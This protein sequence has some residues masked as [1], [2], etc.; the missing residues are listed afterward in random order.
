MFDRCYGCMRPIAVPGAVCPHCGYDP[1]ITEYD[2]SHL[3]AGTVLSGRYVLGKALGLGSFGITYI[4]WD[5]QGQCRVTVKEFLPTAFACHRKGVNAVQFYSAEGRE[6]FE[7]GLDKFREESATLRRLGDLDSIDRILDWVEENGTGYVVMEYL[8]GQT[9]KARLA[10]CRAMSFPEAMAILTPVLRTLDAVHKNG[11]LHRDISPDNIFLCRDGRVKLLDFG[12]AQ[13]DLLRDTEGLSIVLKHG[14]APPE[15]YVPH[16]LAGP[17]TDVFGAAATLYKM[18]TGI[19]PPDVPQRQRE[20]TLLKP[21]DIDCDIPPMAEK[22]MLRALSLRPENRYATASVFLDA[23]LADGVI[24]EPDEEEDETAEKPRRTDGRLQA[25]LIG[26]GAA[27]VIL[28]LVVLL[29][30]MI[31]RA[32]QPSVTQV[33]DSSAAEESSLPDLLPDA[34]PVQYFES[35]QPEAVLPLTDADGAPVSLPYAVFA[36]NGR[37]GLVSTGGAVR[38]QAQYGSIVWDNEK[39]LFLLDG[40]TLWD[41]LQGEVTLP[42]QPEQAQENAAP[43]LS[44]SHYETDGYGLIRV[45]AQGE[46]IAQDGAEGSFLVQG[47]GGWGI[48]SKGTVMVD[49]VYSRATPLSCGVAAFLKGDEWTYFNAYGAQIL[50]D[51]FSAAL[52]PA[53]TAFSFSEGYLPFYDDGTGLWGYVNTSGSIVVEPTYYTALPPMAGCAWVQTEKGF[54]VISFQSEQ[55]GQIRGYC[56]DDLQYVYH[57]QTGTL[58]ILG[59]GSMWDFTQTNVPWLGMRRQL[60]TVQMQG[61]VSYIGA[62]SFFGCSNLTGIRMT[63]DLRGIGAFACKGC[64]QLQQ[65]FLSSAVEAIGDEAFA[66]CGSLTFIEQDGSLANVGVGAF[67]N[68]TALSGVRFS[69][70]ELQLGARSFA[71]CTALTQATLDCVALGDDCFAG[72]TALQSVTLP[73]R[74]AKIGVRI[75]R[76]CTALESFPFPMGVTVVPEEM[77]FGCVS[78]QSASLPDGLAQIDKSAFEGCTALN[79]LSL[80]PTLHTI[81]ERAFYECR[82]LRSV[83]I[84]NSVTRIDSYAFAHCTS[85]TSFDL[86][87]T[88]K[89][90]GANVFEGWTAQQSIRIRNPFLKRLLGTPSGWDDNWDS[91]CNASITSG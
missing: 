67:L 8:S 28:A 19:V 58:D 24:G 38:L 4:G 2:R 52:F 70:G 41:P 29:P 27:I 82:S 14:Y 69:G 53:G 42:G 12:S 55:D 87:D 9:L 34:F 80:P 90:L 31:R 56:G 76:G 45:T 48:V 33:P 89:T 51:S 72:C 13:F 77:F 61:S 50:E 54:G 68:C 59:F 62:N 17:W 25:V 64:A 15:Q 88:V 37:R 63:E 1:R 65:F 16:M 44:D 20:E 21:K 83:L 3:P 60:R 7:K 73:A 10:E 91:G 57:P 46:R 47:S 32:Q 66:G 23:L 43:D 30:R 22:A 74:M 71:G 36:Q 5:S 85:V 86:K 84:P 81:G 79:S 39:Q 49:P 35:F 18:I 75:F 6:R 26:L 11:L 40:S 78:L